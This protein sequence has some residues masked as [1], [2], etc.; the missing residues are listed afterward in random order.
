[1]GRG[2]LGYSPPFFFQE[3]VPIMRACLLLFAVLSLA[4]CDSGFSGNPRDNQPPDTQLSVRDTSLTD[5]LAEED[6]LT[7][8]VR[9]TWSGDDPDGY[10][11]GYEIRYAP[12]GESISSM[13]WER[14]TTRDTLL[15]L[16]IPSGGKVAD[17][18]FEVRAVDQLGAV[19]PTPASTVFPIQNS[20]PSIRLSTFDL[21]PDTTVGVF[22]FAWI[23]DDPE[24]LTNIAAIDVSFND[25]LNF[26][27]VPADVDF[28]TFILETSDDPS[29]TVGTAR[30]FNGRSLQPTDFYFD[31][32][33]LNADNTIYLRSVDKTDTTSAR[34][35]YTWWVK[36][37]TGSILF[38]NDYRKSTND[39]V[40]AFHLDLLK[41]YLP[42]DTK[43]DTW[44]ISEPYVTG[45]T[46]NAPRSAAL[47]PNLSPT[48]VS[49]FNQY[50]H[51]YWV[52]SA[53]TNRIAGNNFPAAASVLSDFFREGGTIM[54]HSPMLAP[55]DPEEV[56]SN[57]A[58]TTLP[59]NNLLTLPDSLRRLSLTPGA[60]IRAAT[61]SPLSL[62][63]L[64]PQSIVIGPLPYEA[65]TAATQPL[66]VADFTYRL[67]NNRSGTWTTPNVI[68]SIS[69]DRRVGLFSLPLVDENTGRALLTDPDG[70]E[71]AAREAVFAILAE[72]GFPR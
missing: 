23:P 59:L 36:P 54:V 3:R 64:T 5:N 45:N 21:P 41:E 43:V 29:D 7:S 31:N 20:P 72:L 9:I 46:G 16:P 50:D 67:R 14:T 19:D 49:F 22:T 6:R 68:A 4:A 57:P 70:D 38:V 2:V 47:P 51:I 39:V 62:P 1:M 8:T 27:R 69:T 63:T 58:V 42:A 25:T 12:N 61:N 24:G 17:V 26:T 30:M 11:V 35:E 37:V 18:Q 33:R 10:V 44:Y 34:I 55:S 52:S 66:Y 48:L 53:T 65:S 71:E 56:L 40:S 15:L 32:I 60:E 28:A 13:P